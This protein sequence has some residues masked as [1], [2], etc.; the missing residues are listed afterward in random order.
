MRDIV[1]YVSLQAQTSPYFQPREK[2]KCIEHIEKV[3]ASLRLL[4]E[5]MKSEQNI[6]QFQITGLNPETIKSEQNVSQFHIP[7]LN[8]VKMAH[9]FI[10]HKNIGHGNLLY[11]GRFFHYY[12]LDESMSL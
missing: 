8:P 5:T 1:S 3:K 2:L 10:M 9:V 12:V 4:P 7:G 11:T 6:S